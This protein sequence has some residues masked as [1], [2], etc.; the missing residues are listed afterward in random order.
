MKEMKE[1]GSHNLP[2]EKDQSWNGQLKL[3]QNE[4]TLHLVV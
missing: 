1:Q 2:D 4:N 3:Y